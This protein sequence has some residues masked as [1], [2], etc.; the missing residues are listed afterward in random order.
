MRYPVKINHIIQN[1]VKKCAIFSMPEEMTFLCKY[2][3]FLGLVKEKI[4][5]VF[6]ESVKK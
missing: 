4:V 6:Y 5:S 1:F 3:I 2:Y